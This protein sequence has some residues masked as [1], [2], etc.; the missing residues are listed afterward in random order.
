MK[1]TTVP[2][3]TP[4]AVGDGETTEASEQDRAPNRCVLSL[5]SQ[6]SSSTSTDPCSRG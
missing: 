6:H 4:L 5:I 3:S 2:K 1:K